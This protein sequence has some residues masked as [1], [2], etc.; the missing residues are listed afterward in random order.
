M[1]ELVTKKRDI[2]SLNVEITKTKVMG[3]E[4]RRF[5]T[6][7]WIGDETS[8][9][10]IIIAHGQ[11][12]H[13]LVY[14]T[15][16][17]NFVKEGY[18]VYALDHIGHGDTIK[19]KKKLGLWDEKSFTKSAY[20]IHV[21]IDMAKKDFPD[22]KITVLGHDLGG[23]LI[24]KAIAKF[25]SPV[26]SLVLSGIHESAFKLR[27]MKWRFFWGKKLHLDSKPSFGGERFINRK[28]NKWFVFGSNDLD[29]VTSDKEAL[30]AFKEDP[31]CGFTYTYAYYYYH[32]CS[33]I[34]FYKGKSIDKLKKN[35]PILVVGGS[36]DSVNGFG[37][38]TIA[39]ANYLKKDFKLKKVNVKMYTGARHYIYI[40]SC[41]YKLI[42]DIIR[43]NETNLIKKE[44]TA[45]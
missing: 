45:N 11:S 43:W 21:L 17:K 40:D 3:A 10:T 20:N 4:A 42:D 41:K 14:D 2:S 33:L 27:L 7:K 23:S 34:K 29:W 39:F 12:E 26:D 5:Q 24:I 13:A 36:A 28:Y 6:Y 1:A 25:N 8:K 31:K 15:V 18:A 35:L 32:V 22:N 30:A 16:A 37:K 9:G 38:G 19:D 44:A